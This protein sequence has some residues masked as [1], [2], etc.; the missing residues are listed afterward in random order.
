MLFPFD[1][2]LPHVRAFGADFR[3]KLAI[4]DGR[5]LETRGKSGRRSCVACDQTSR[6]ARAPLGGCAT[7]RSDRQSGGLDQVHR[8]G[9]ARANP[10]FSVD[11][12]FDDGR[13]AR[14]DLAEMVESAAV[15]APFR[16]PAQ[17]VSALAIVEDG[18][19]L[20]WSDQ[21]ELHA[22]SLRYRAFPEELAQDYGV[23][24]V[25]HGRPAA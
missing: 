15:A 8:I 1:H 22:D 18:D 4:G 23:Q 10:D 14:I 9:H 24:R 16:G 7:R 17:F 19:V 20:R 3:V 13:V 5:V 12:K 11:L 25:G 2:D 21:F 6:P